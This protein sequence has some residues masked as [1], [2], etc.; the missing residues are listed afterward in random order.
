MATTCKKEHQ[1]A[2]LALRDGGFTEMYSAGVPEDAP[3]RAKRLQGQSVSILDSWRQSLF[4][5]C[6]EG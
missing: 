1:H 6:F 4:R 3:K 5:A 2:S